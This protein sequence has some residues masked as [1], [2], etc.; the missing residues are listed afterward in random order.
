[1]SESGTGMILDFVFVFWPYPLARGIVVPQ[2]GIEPVPPAVE[3]WSPN[4]LT[5]W[6][7]P[8]LIFLSF[9]KIIMCAF[10]LG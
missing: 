10:L 1:M 5:T 8:I 2:S 9:F 7:V 4:H 6:E 3:A